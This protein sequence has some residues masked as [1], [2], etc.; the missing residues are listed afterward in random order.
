MLPTPSGTGWSPSP[1]LLFMLC[2]IWQAAQCSPSTTN[3]GS[4]NIVHAL[5]RLAGCTVFAWYDKRRCPQ[6]CLCSDASGRLYNVRLTWPDSTILQVCRT[7][8]GTVLGITVDLSALPYLLRLLPGPTPS[9]RLR[10]VVPSRPRLCRSGKSNEQRSGVSSVGE[11]GSESDCGSTSA[12]PSYQ[13]P[14]RCLGL[15]LCI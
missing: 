13:G 8:Q 2:C 3:T 15:S 10:S 14:D 9:G 7:W 12:R 4:H 6:Y 1:T 5:T 11:R